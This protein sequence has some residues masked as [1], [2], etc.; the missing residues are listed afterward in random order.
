MTIQQIEDAIRGL[1]ADELAV[2]R[3][4]FAGFDAAAWDRQLERDVAAG[5]LDLLVREGLEDLNAGR[6]TDL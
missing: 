1:S 2:F 4:W 6:T 5:K 3:A